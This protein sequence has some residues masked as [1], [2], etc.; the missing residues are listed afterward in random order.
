VGGVSGTGGGRAESKVWDRTKSGAGGAVG[1]SG[2]GFA[3]VGGG[4]YVGESGPESSLSICIQSGKWLAW[5]SCGGG[6]WGGLEISA[7][8]V[9]MT[10]GG[11]SGACGGLSE[12][13][14]DAARSLIWASVSSEPGVH[15]MSGRVL[16]GVPVRHFR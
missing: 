9:R 11:M 13:G 2:A 4:E 12:V 6:E 1:V 10:T 8:G 15:S 7:G 16:K 3:G 14:E 5:A